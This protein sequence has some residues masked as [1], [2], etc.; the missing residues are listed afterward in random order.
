MNHIIRLLT[1]ALIFASCKKEI[2][3][4]ADIIKSDFNLTTDL[5]DFKRKMTESDTIHIWFNHSMC[6]YHVIE[7][8]QITRNSDSLK[9]RSEVTEDTFDD[10]PEWQTAYEKII[11]INDTLW[12]FEDFLNRNS[13]RLNTGKKE[14]V[15]LQVRHKGIKLDY[16]TTTLDDLTEFMTNYYD[17]MRK[18]YPENKNGIYGY[19]RVED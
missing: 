11:P 2:E 7:R 19:M 8:I 15:T 6:T 10:A 16:Y 17:T 13:K 3:H 1:L 9:V 18:L 12:N 5:T 4:K 14:Y